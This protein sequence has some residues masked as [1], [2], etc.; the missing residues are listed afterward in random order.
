[1]EMREEKS[2]REAGREKETERQRQGERKYVS[3]HY[4]LTKAW[5]ETVRQMALKRGKPGRNPQIWLIPGPSD[6]R[7]G[8]DLAMLFKN[9]CLGYIRDSEQ[10]QVVCSKKQNKTK[11]NIF[12]YP[13]ILPFINKGE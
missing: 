2:R 1:M 3:M 9:L 7:N 6:S 12:L 11:A 8:A 5:K 13:A 4:L 10:S